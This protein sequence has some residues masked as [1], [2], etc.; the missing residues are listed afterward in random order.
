MKIPHFQIV[1][2]IFTLTLLTSCGDDKA[3]EAAAAQAL[4]TATEKT[5]EP[6]VSQ[7]SQAAQKT[8]GTLNLAIG[9]QAA[10]KGKETCVAVTARNF[11]AVVS[12]QYSLKWDAKVLKFKG[13]QGFNLPGLSANSFGTQ[14]TSDGIL[15]HSWFDANV[16]GIS[17]PDD[18]K[19]YEICFETVGK[20]GSK[21]AVEFSNT[22]VIFEISNA[23]SQFLALDGQP[24]TVEVK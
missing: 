24:G 3:R 13:L 11:N 22:P 15:T 4:Q 14:A 20:A 12:M 9:N 17:R 7:Q 1:A 23:N 8:V 6:I 18:T 19:L 10:A 5:A 21:S 2:A 16:K